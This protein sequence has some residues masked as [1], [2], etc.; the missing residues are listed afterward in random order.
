MYQCHKI[1][2]G[3]EDDL[4]EVFG[5]ERCSADQAAVDVAL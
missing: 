1:L 4:G 3:C 5:F 2:Y